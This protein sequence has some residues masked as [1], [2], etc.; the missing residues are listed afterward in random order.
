MRIP[1]L[2]VAMVPLPI[3]PKLATWLPALN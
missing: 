2:S 3:S 1:M